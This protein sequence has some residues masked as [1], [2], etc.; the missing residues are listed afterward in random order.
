MF[1]YHQ[2]MGR[3]SR[4]CNCYKVAK[5]MKKCS[6]CKNHFY[7]SA[8]CQA[9]NRDYHRIFCNQ[10]IQKSSL[11]SQACDLT[12]DQIHAF[13]VFRECFSHIREPHCMICGDTQDL[14]RNR[15]GVMC[16]FCERVQL[17]MT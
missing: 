12:D 8:E 4:C 6:N 10:I 13:K 2:K 7:C 17:S 9:E 16:G 14:Y 3:L 5:K 15:N 1:S 11:D